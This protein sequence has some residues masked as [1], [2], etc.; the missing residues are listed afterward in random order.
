MYRIP[1]ES[2]GFPNDFCVIDMLASVPSSFKANYTAWNL[3][4]FSVVFMV[5]IYKITVHVNQA[6]Y[7]TDMS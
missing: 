2:S 3:R 5:N 6:F 4:I 7:L 1:V